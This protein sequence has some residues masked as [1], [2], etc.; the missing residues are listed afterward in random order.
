MFNFPITPDLCRFATYA[1]VVCVL[2]ILVSVE[3][4][5]FALSKTDFRIKVEY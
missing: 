2:I 5:F 4:D 3:T 1:V